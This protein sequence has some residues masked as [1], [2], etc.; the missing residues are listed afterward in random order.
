[1]KT[2]HLRQTLLSFERKSSIYQTVLSAPGIAPG[3][4][5]N[6]GR[7]RVAG[8]YRRSGIAPCLEDKPMIKLI[9]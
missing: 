4:T 5:D 6:E 1:M 8:F 2:V 9:S 3:S 7:H